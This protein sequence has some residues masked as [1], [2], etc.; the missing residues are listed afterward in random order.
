[1]TAGPIDAHAHIVP[2]SLI[3]AIRARGEALGVT[4]APPPAG[5]APALLFADGTRL[6]PFFAKLAEPEAERMASMAATGL[7]RQVLSAWTDMLGFG[8]APAQA[9]A[10]H[11]A[12]NEAFADLCRR[13]P[14]RFSFLAT[15]AL[16][17][18]QA[19]AAELR[20]AVRE[21]GAV[22]AAAPA[23]F[24]GV[25]IGELE[26]D[27]WW[28]AADETGRP[29][30]IHPVDLAP[31]PRVRRWGLAQVASYTFD[32]T[33]AAASLI[34]MGVLDRFPGLRVFLPHGG[35]AFVWLSGRLDC[36]AGRV[37]AELR[38]AAQRPPSRYIDRFLF[39]SILHDPALLRILVGLVGAERV[40]LG[41][42]DGFPP[43]DRDPLGT[44]RAAGLP[45]AQTAAIAAGNARAAFGLWGANARHADDLPPARH[46]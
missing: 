44:L 46:L 37:P 36:M 14:G 22:G 33:L 31:G 9:V 35:G 41:T 1:M 28:A 27:P 11:R 15:G 21:D 16:Q 34:H 12:M 30:L 25:N 40:M 19:A 7:A 4:Y 43:A 23:N 29:V 2:D 45:E 39:D 32:T 42:D 38:G 24:A 17:D 3:A 20:R 13:N 6:R 8:L 10:W 26:L 18:P 5:G